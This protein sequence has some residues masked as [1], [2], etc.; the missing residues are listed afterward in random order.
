MAGKSVKRSAAAVYKGLR[1]KFGARAE[2]AKKDALDQI[3]FHVLLL[4]APAS[5]A[6][7]AFSALKSDYVDWN[8]VRVTSLDEIASVLK[9][10]GSSANEAPSIKEFLQK[11]YLTSHTITAEPLQN[12]S[13]KRAREFL[14]STTELAEEQII[15]ILLEPLNM[16]ITPVNNAIRQALIRLGISR[17]GA[18]LIQAQSG[19]TA[20]AAN[21]KPATAYRLLRVLTRDFCREEEQ[22]CRK[23][24]VKKHCPTGQQ[25]IRLEKELPKKKPASEKA[26]TVEKKKKRK[27]T[28]RIK[29]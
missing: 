26:V 22:L 7:K 3:I 27:K 10:K 16:P 19:F 29:K 4:N 23:C 20:I 12:L 15:E 1:K 14:K 18:T 9:S 11:L 13:P 6:E 25:R 8:E 17:K 21:G 2:Y 5:A 24:P 28:A